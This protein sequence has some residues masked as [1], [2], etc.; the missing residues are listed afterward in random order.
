MVVGLVLFILV[1][2]G[3]GNVM[4]MTVMERKREI[5]TLRAIGM[6]KNQV[7]SLFLAEGF[8]IGLIGAAVGLL[9]ANGLTL[10]IAAHGGIPL[11]PPPGTNQGI[12]IIPQMSVMTS[13]FGAA[14]PLLVSVLAAWWP[15][16][17]SANLNPVE[18]LMET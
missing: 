6:E 16:S 1:G 10:L 11:P 12:S 17:A 2:G 18:A 15:A 14:M 13:V 7:R 8:I 9:V 3:I 5:G 4:A